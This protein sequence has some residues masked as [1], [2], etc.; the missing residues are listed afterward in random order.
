MIYETTQPSVL[1]TI[2]LALIVW[3]LYRKEKK[4]EKE[5]AWREEQKRK[6][7]QEFARKMRE[8]DKQREEEKRKREEEAEKY[9]KELKTI[10]VRLT[11]E[12]NEKEKF[13]RKKSGDFMIS[14]NAI[15]ML[16]QVLHQPTVEKQEIL[17]LLGE[18]EKIYCSVFTTNKEDQERME[19]CKEWL[20]VG[21]G[22]VYAIGIEIYRQ[23]LTQ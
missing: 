15:Y 10:S 2:V 23:Y 17:D 21:E 19:Y 18:G 22:E 12:Q 14:A 3:H 6:R 7:N 11:E 20:G 1:L 13:C 16:Y 8:Q 9:R 5:R 4:K